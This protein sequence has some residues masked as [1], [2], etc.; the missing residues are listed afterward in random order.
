MATSTMNMETAIEQKKESPIRKIFSNH[1]FRMLWL[2][3]GTSLVGDQFMMIALPWLVL[4]TTGD[5][6]ALGIILALQGIPRAVFMLLG[7][8]ITDRFSQRMVMI[9]SDALRFIM[10]A[11]LVLMI[12]TGNTSLWLLYVF[13]LIF[14]TL[15]GF[16]LPAS[17]SIVPRI[18]GSDELMV[19]NSIVQGTA[20]L[21]VFIGPLLAGGLIALF[22]NSHT[23]I[24]SSVSP[25]ISGIALAFT[26]D[27]FT[28][29][30]SIL[31][32]WL[33]RIESTQKAREM[34]N[35]VFSSIKEG[36]FFV[37]KTPKIFM[38]FLL[39]AAINFLFA[40][41]FFVGIPVMA[42]SRLAEGAAAFGILMAAYGIGNLIGIVMS[43]A[44]KIKPQNLGLISVAVIGMFGVGMALFGFINS[45]WVGFAILFL[46]GIMNGYISVVIITMLQKNTPPE[47]MGRLMS[48]T[49][50][51]MVGLVPISQAISG[52]LIKFSLEGLF[53]GCGILIIIMAIVAAMSKEV[54]NFG[55]ETPVN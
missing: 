50:F 53:L 21:S 39:I 24:S 19:G 23:S 37:W 3:Q 43:G 38:M 6:L 48:I 36:I 41:P 8:A 28:F 18:I 54:R 12:L 35:D 33:M 10:T 44:I 47:M 5:P 27:A 22:S 20:Q 31:T 40:G 9:V 2:G 34:S 17:Q 11:S 15:S 46:L 49:V 25:T 29:I 52:E 51:A 1:N 16:F 7:G 45:T 4:M 13:A 42:N 26:F 30:I 55:V 32:L 14:G